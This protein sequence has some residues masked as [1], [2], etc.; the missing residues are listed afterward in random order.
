M[1]E[2]EIL[3]IFLMPMSRLST[4]KMLKMQLQTSNGQP[5]K[6]Q[7]FMQIFI[8]SLVFMRFSFHILLPDMPKK[9][10]YLTNRGSLWESVGTLR[11][12][13]ANLKVTIVYEVVPSDNFF[14]SRICLLYR[15]K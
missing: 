8:S 2:E 14:V 4:W 7:G 9:I 11:L 13:C 15:N 3:A 5:S 1:D 6:I 12:L 10:A